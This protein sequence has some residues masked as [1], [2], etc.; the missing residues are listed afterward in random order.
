MTRQRP[1]TAPAICLIALLAPPAALAKMPSAA[2]EQA[3]VRKALRDDADHYFIGCDGY[4][5]PS[6]FGDG[7]TAEADEVVSGQRIAPML[8]AQAGDT[9]RR[10]PEFGLEG[11]GDCGAALNDIQ[12]RPNYWE[13]KVSLLRARALHRFAVGDIPG[14]RSDLAAAGATVA[15]TQVDQF[16]QRSLK[17]SLDLENAFVLS[18]SG[19]P[20]DAERLAMTAWSSRPFSRQT[21]EAAILALGPA[22]T[23]SDA[24][25]LDDRLAALDTD[26]QGVPTI[27]SLQEPKDVSLSSTPGS[28]DIVREFYNVLPEPETAQRTAPDGGANSALNNQPI[29]ATAPIGT[30][31]H[32]TF[33]G[34]YA[35]QSIAEEQSLLRA[36]EAATSVGKSGFIIVK[37][38]GGFRVGAH[39]TGY[40]VVVVAPMVFS[41]SNPKC[42]GRFHYA[43]GYESGLDV[44][45]VDPSAPPAGYEAKTE[46]IINAA[47][48]KDALRPVYKATGSAQ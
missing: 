18:R 6:E 12:A 24:K 2:E 39:R 47:A 34:S 38:T 27:A 5:A 33:A 10:T 40:C 48:V 11:I 41:Y 4:G 36:A 16:Y 35:T 45:A 20:T 1:I 43:D 25:S 19:D 28:G 8:E 37:R 9:V 46:R 22:A 31:I 14:S 15:P 17:L 32:V 30:L 29:P 42:G 3:M 26:L 44:I 7:M 21:T 23:Q 13:R